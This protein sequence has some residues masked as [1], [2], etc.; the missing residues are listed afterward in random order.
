LPPKLSVI[1]ATYNWSS[2]LRCSIPSVLYQSFADF[3]LLVIGDACTDDSEAVVR[4]FDDPRVSWH[5][6]PERAGSQSGPNNFGLLI[7]RGE[8]VAY[9]G[10]D[11][12]W[13]PDHLR[14]LLA[15]VE[16]ERAGLGCSVAAMY[17]PRGSGIRGI[18]GVLANGV[19]SPIEFFPPS[20]IMH[21]RGLLIWNM[22][23][24][25][26][27]PVDCDL[28]YRA[29][30]LGTKIV[31]SGFLNVFKFN[32]AWRRDSYRLR[33]TTDQESILRRLQ[34]NPAACVEAELIDLLRA[35][36]EMRLLH[37]RMAT[38]Q[39]E[40]FRAEI[41]RFRG[42][43]SEPPPANPSQTRFHP[44]FSFGALEWYPPEET[45]EWGVIRWSGPALESTMVLPVAPSDNF[46]LRIQV[47][48]WFPTPIEEEL[49]LFVND[50]P[51]DYT[52]D[53]FQLTVNPIAGN[54]EPVRICFAVKR[55]RSPHFESNGQ[56]KDTR[57]LGIC[58]NWVE[59]EEIRTAASSEA[60]SSPPQMSVSR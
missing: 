43:E 16:R 30:A 11:D 14:N 39:T 57:W 20:S 41:K 3:E 17:G 54:G 59:I 42:L 51:V 5:N 9:L 19:D 48:N 35:S 4:S 50:A 52:V 58:L 53:G 38:S 6:L 2:A 29:R 36:L 46:R 10:H 34:E 56:S 55:T 8:Y 28:L 21:R 12:V 37:S 49:E 13:H 15:V 33:D 25:N 40:T 27:L 31:S 47:L 18:S 44:D 32:S 1:I 23:A 26:S 22:P 45:A 60:P 24:G 7:A